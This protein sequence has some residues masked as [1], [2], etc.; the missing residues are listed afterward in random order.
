[1]TMRSFCYRSD[2]GVHY[3]LAV[4]LHSLASR[5]TFMLASGRSSWG[6]K[7]ADCDSDCNVRLGRAVRF[8][9]MVSAGAPGMSHNECTAYSVSAREVT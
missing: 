6:D 9:P 2:V 7:P 5:C 3:R 8:V 4:G 1:M